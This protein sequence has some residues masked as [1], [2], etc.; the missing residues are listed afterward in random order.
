M[1]NLKIYLAAIALSVV[2]SCSKED[3]NVL[4][5][6]QNENFS[7]FNKN[8]VVE[9][10]YVALIDKNDPGFLKFIAAVEDNPFIDKYLTA[11]ESISLDGAITFAENTVNG[12]QTGYIAQVINENAEVSGAIYGF[13]IEEGAIASFP[14]IAN[15]YALI[16]EKLNDF[17]TPLNLMNGKIT[18]YDLNYD[19]KFMEREYVEGDLNNLITFPILSGDLNG[20]VSSNGWESDCRGGSNGN[21]SWGECMSCLRGACS[22]D[23]DCND[24]MIAVDRIAF[25]AMMPQY[26]T[27]SS[28]GVACV[29]ISWIY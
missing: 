25:G 11:D 20:N 16:I 23:N 19:K 1:K 26:S 12:F 10:E 2:F 3:E 28:M 4:D 8:I 9:K 5:S 15:E 18:S 13:K 29:A 22:N 6:V 14:S 17:E 7:T 24:M 27:W 21:V